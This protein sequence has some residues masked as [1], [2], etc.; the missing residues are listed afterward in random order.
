MGMLCYLQM[1]PV[2]HRRALKKP[3]ADNFEPFEEWEKTEE[4]AFNLAN[5]E[6]WFRAFRNSP[7]AV[8][9]STDN[10]IFT[11]A[12][13][14]AG[15][16]EFNVRNDRVGALYGQFMK[17]L[18]P[19]LVITRDGDVGTWGSKG[20]WHEEPPCDTAN[21]HYPD[22]NVETWVRDW[23]RV[24]E[25]HPA[26][27]GETLYT[28]YG[29]WDNW[30]GAKPEVVRKKALHVRRIASLYRE[31]GVPGQILHGPFQRRLHRT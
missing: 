7:S 15:K 9:W 1:Y 31:L 24:Y 14:T 20:R 3:S 25:W 16:A 23:Q 30:V 12:W 22:F 27:F 29:A 21:Y 10:E 13:D 26:V 6:R 18:D 19:Q 2:L 5:Y 8:I 28:S 11:Q 4:H 17:K